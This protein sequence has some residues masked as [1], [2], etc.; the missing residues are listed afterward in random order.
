M[1]RVSP[2]AVDYC[3]KSCHVSYLDLPGSRANQQCQSQVFEEDV[4]SIFFLDKLL[5]KW[6]TSSA[7]VR[8]GAVR[9][10]N[11]KNMVLG[12]R[13]TLAQIVTVFMAVCV[14]LNKL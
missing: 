4:Y 14:T 12:I 9:C 8:H 10:S 1:L 2:S 3:Q 11:G 6:G 13:L 5:P 7:V